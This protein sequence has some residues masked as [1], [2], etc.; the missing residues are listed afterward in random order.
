MAS[1]RKMLKFST[2]FLLGGLIL[3]PTAEADAA[4]QNAS[5]RNAAME[6]TSRHRVRRIYRHR[7]AP[8]YRITEYYVPRP[9]AYDYAPSY[10]AWGGRSIYYRPPSSAWPYAHPPYPLIAPG[11]W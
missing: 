11:G 9:Y 2:L 3:L 5:A 7:G 8:R 1:F 10:R 4:G 6:I